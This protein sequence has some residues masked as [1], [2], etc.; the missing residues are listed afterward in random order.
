MKS[1]SHFLGILLLLIDF[2][3][4]LVWAKSEDKFA[5]VIGNEAYTKF[6]S[7]DNPVIDARGVDAALRA[8]GFQVFFYKNLATKQDMER[9]ISS[10]VRKLTN[11]TVG[12]FYYA[13]HGI[14]V[15]G[16][17]YLI[18]TAANIRSEKEVAEQ[19]LSANDDLLSQMENKRLGVN[20]IILDACRNNPLSATKTRGLNSRGADI[21]EKQG[22]VEM[23]SEEDTIIVYATAANEE[24]QDGRRGEH[25]PFTKNL[26]RGLKTKGISF[27]DMIDVVGREVRKDVFQRP[28]VYHPAGV[29]F[30]IDCRAGTQQPQKP[31][32]APSSPSRNITI[33]NV[34]IP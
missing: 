13:G 7:L 27:L 28:Y 11:R 22:L 15:K 17:N 18:P 25:S 32:P 14:Q 33:P 3:G 5:L 6:R 29:D 8:A 34:V 2:S 19:A 23:T 30:C 20:V 26:I 21:A 24:A 1:L 4:T 16:K 10:F 9:A 12:L 31:Q